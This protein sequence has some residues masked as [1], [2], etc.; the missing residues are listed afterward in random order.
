M[1]EELMVDRIQVL[2]R[3]T[4]EDSTG[5]QEET[6]TPQAPIAAWAAQLGAKEVQG[7]R[8]TAIAP[9]VFI[10][11]TGT[12]ITA[13]DQVLYNGMTFHVEGPPA[14]AHTPDGEH[15]M[16]VTATWIEG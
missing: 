10:V 15:H 6:F 1:L 5:D 7:G 13:Y 3:T 8:D 9:W 14:N 12:E 2:R 16:R 4:T 11:P